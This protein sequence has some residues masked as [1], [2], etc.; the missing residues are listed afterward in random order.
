MT[1]VLESVE[2]AFGKV[3]QYFACPIYRK[4]LKLLLQPIVVCVPLI[5]SNPR[6]YDSVTLDHFSLPPPTYYLI[7]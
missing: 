3:V 5:N 2:W 7:I 6:L 4:H 1:K